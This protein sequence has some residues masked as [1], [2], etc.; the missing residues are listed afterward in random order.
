[1]QPLAGMG[2]ETQSAWFCARRGCFITCQGWDEVRFGQPLG[3]PRGP[4]AREADGLMWRRF[5][6]G[7]NVSWD[8]GANTT[9]IEWPKPPPQ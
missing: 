7:L 1:M 6:S 4:A 3:P 9:V 2:C 8:T 5:G